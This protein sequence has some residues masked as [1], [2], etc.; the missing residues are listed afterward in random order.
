MRAASLKAFNGDNK[1][2]MFNLHLDRVVVKVSIRCFADRMVA[3]VV[4]T[5]ESEEAAEQHS[6]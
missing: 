6:A 5:A 3:K 2:G 1:A 4:V